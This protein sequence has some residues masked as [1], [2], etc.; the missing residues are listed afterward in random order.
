MMR[1]AH[2]YI[3]RHVNFYL[4][5]WQDYQLKWNPDDYGGIQVTRVPCNMGWNPDDYGGIQ[6]TRVPC[7][8]G[9][10]PDIVLLNK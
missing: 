1:G 7:N 8:M 10:K 5:L 3:I 4:K 6:V 2:C 9:W